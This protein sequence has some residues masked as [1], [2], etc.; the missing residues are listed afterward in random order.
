MKSKP[1][2]RPPVPQSGP[3]FEARRAALLAENEAHDAWLSPAERD[4]V[5]GT[6]AEEIDARPIDLGKELGG[7]DRRKKEFRVPRTPRRR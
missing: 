5:D 7:A 3:E 2:A 6:P 4:L 1:A